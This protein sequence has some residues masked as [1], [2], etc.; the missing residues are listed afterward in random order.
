MIMTE[1]R[2]IQRRDG[3]EIKLNRIQSASLMLLL[4]CGLLA[5]RSGNDD[6]DGSE[7]LRSAKD[8][9]GTSS[10]PINIDYQIMGMPVVGIPLSINLKIRSASEQ[11]IRVKFRINDLTSLEFSDAQSETVSVIPTGD[12]EY[13]EEQVTV[14]P[15]R[16]GRLFLNVAA[17]IE[18][19]VG[20]TATVMAIPI[21]VGRGR[22]GRLTAGD[23]GDTPISTPVE[24]D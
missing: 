16:E 10:V 11:P 12:E 9:H 14:I 23:A 24:E 18:T 21:P 19:D 1:T 13:S 22:S 7:T 8:V 6:L 4:L 5:C 2:I 15:Q 20:M 17:E 3:R